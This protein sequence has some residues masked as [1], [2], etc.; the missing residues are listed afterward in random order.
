MIQLKMMDYLQMHDDTYYM[1][2]IQRWILRYIMNICTVPLTLALCCILLS[3]IISKL[4]GFCNGLLCQR[5]DDFNSMAQDQE[6]ETDAKTE[7]ETERW[8][9]F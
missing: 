8:N 7:T 4:L 9:L 6:T 5:I 3:H 1:F 2:A